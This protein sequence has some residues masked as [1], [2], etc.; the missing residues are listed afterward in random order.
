VELAAAYGVQERKL[1]L[2][3]NLGFTF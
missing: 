2:H 3:M 1:R